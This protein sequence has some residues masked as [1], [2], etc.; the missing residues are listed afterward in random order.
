MRN[1][2]NSFSVFVDG[3]CAPGASLL[4]IEGSV[5][6]N[7]TWDGSFPFIVP[8]AVSTTECSFK[9]KSTEKQDLCAQMSMLILHLPNNM[10]ISLYDE[11]RDDLH[12]REKGRDL[13]QS[14]D[15]SPYTHRK[16]QKASWQHKKA[17]KTLITQRLRTDDL[18]RS[19]GGTAVTP[20]MW[21]NRFTS[22]QPSHLP[23]QP[24]NQKDSQWIIR[25]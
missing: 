18:G 2:N 6:Y 24:C 14:Y 25:K 11:D 9:F 19:V 10:K 8:H 16:I 15:K 12:V 22:A 13:T 5:T 7:I 23:Q 3:S 17:T 1:I 21:L 4:N 20:L